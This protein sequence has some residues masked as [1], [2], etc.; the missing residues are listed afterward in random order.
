MLVLVFNAGS[1]SLKYAV[2]RA[3]PGQDRPSAAQTDFTGSVEDVGQSYD[4]AAKRAITELRQRFG[5]TFTPDLI[6]H[7]VVHG[8]DHFGA[9]API[10][11]D[12]IAAIE[13]WSELAPLHNNPALEVI[14]QVQAALPDVSAVAVFDTAFHRRLPEYAYTYALPYEVAQDL[15][16][17]RY[18]FHGISH[19]Y[20]LLRYAELAQRRPEE[21]ELITLHLES[22][23]SAAAISGGHS[24]DTSM[25]FTPLE[26]LVMGSRCGD[27]DPAI[28]PYLA[29][30]RSMDITAVEHLMNNDSGLLG[31]SGISNDTRELAARI[32]TDQRARLA[33]EVFSYRVRKYVGAY[34]AV[35]ERPE[36]IIFSGGIGE[37]T[38]FVREFVCAGL[39][40]FGIDVDNALNDSVVEGDVLISR[41]S[42]RI[43]VWGIHSEEALMIAHEA[44]KTY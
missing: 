30:K 10:D 9:P 26:G 4:T 33:L 40:S 22:G 35:L 21:I 25:G 15:G 20:Q 16:I 39:R 13:K 5:Q 34:L 6:A 24:V 17:R 43:A 36:A 32:D 1:N 41:P 11:A 2:I 37:N 7:R 42:S 29:R 3:E 19:R 8:G 38:P 27:I 12:V 31:L 14:R 28:V 44:V 18:G 23:S